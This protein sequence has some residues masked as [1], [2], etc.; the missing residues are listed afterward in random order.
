MRGWVVWLVV[1][2]S[3]NAAVAAPAAPDRLQRG[4]MAADLEQLVVAAK[5]GW[6]YFDHR[7]ALGL[8]LDALLATTID[9]LP[10]A[11]E[12]ADFALVVRRFVA[13]LEDGHAWVATPGLTEQRDR[14][15]PFQLVDT[16][17]G[18]VVGRVS[19][20][21]ARPRRGDALVAVDGV[22]T[23][24]LLAAAGQRTPASTPA[25]RRALALQSLRLTSARSHTF[26]FR[27]PS[28]RPFTSDL[29]TTPLARTAPSPAPLEWLSWKHLPGG[30]GYLRIA[31]LAA[32][33]RTQWMK[34]LPADR[35][36]LLAG[37]Y[38]SLDDA[39]ASISASRALI[40]DLR[41]DTGG[42]DLLGMR[43]AQHLLPGGTTFYQ[44]E[45]PAAGAVPAT[46]HVAV[47][48][49]TTATITP[50][51]GR[52][53]VL[54]DSL[55]FSAT[56]NLVAC[57]RATRP[58]TTFIGRPTGGG[59]GAPRHATTL[60]HSGFEVGFSTIRVYDPAGQLIEGRGTTP[61]LLVTT[62][63]A[64]VLRQ[65][66]SDLRAALRMLRSR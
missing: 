38:A 2:V 35:D 3:A 32:R 4:D 30:I 58:E 13:A 52:V 1:L 54:I 11:A 29:A 22:A 19:V 51:P 25:M 65:R 16:R 64:D 39:F 36:Q 33:D 40:L 60:A 66:D 56:D 6:A 7:R 26:T 46:P 17:E 50:F 61:D 20:G 23:G 53:I 55:S 49:P 62:T 8:D 27:R 45:P 37:Q 42:T 15:W 57:L 5:Q 12:R 10:P 48:I 18:V 63:R 59:T 41:G 34:A 44:L 47:T 31:S 24:D 21:L 14:V 28:G 9:G 43:V